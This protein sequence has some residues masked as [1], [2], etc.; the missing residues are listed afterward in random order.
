MK[1][2]NLYKKLGLHNEQEVF[3]YLIKTLNDTIF[4]WDYFVQFNKIKSKIY[5]FETEL[6]ILNV[7]IGKKDIDNYF[8]N[9]LTEYPNIREVLPLL[10]AVRQ[11]KLKELKIINNLET[12]EKYSPYDLFDPNKKLTPQLKTRLLNFFKQSGLRSIFLDRNVKNL[13]DYCFGIETGLDSNARKNRTGSAMEKIT[14]HL[15]RKTISH[16]EYL[17]I[18]TQATPK[19]IETSFGFKIKLSKASKRFD[20]AIFNTKKRN[21][22]LIETN[23]YS[24]GGSKLKATA[25][26]YKSMFRLFKE[27]GIQYVW[28]T[29]GLGW[30]SSKNILYETFL[31]NDY[32]FNLNLLRLGILNELF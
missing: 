8:I 22:T 9:L 18:L 26:E 19:K 23:Y 11:K 27:Q 32:L 29:D 2:L 7:L 3:D 6:N 14:E 31:N 4:T 5:R 10:I 17:S 20:F 30:L 28:V 21:L 1:Y 12:L 16:K 15:I 13:V 25:G 24:V